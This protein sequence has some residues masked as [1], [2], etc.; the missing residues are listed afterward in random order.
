MALGVANAS[1]GI[2]QGMPI[3]VS[4]SR[5]AVNDALRAP[6]QIAGMMAAG[7]IAII[8]LFLTDPIGD[9]PKAVRGARGHTEILVFDAEALTMQTGPVTLTVARAR[10]R[11]RGAASGPSG[12]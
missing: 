6:S 3:G 4:G 10:A 7:A 8:L 12:P 11:V 5:T 9:L 1:A 2:S